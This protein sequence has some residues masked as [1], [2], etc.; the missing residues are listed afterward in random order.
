[1]RKSKSMFDNSFKES[2]PKIAEFF[3]REKT[4]LTSNPA[5][6]R[7]NLIELMERLRTLLLIPGTSGKVKTMEHLRVIYRILAEEVSKALLLHNYREFSKSKIHE[8]KGQAQKIATR[9][10]DKFPKVYEMLRKDVE[11]VFEWDPA[12]KSLE[13]VELAYP[14]IFAILCYR[15]AH[16]LY[17]ENVP[18]IPRFITEYAHSQTGID[19]HP[20]AEI[21]EYFFIDHGTGVVIGET[22]KIGKRVRI[23]HGV[24]LGSKKVPLDESGNP[25]KGVPRHPVIEDDVVIYAHAMVLGRVKVGRGSIIGAGCIITEDVPPFSKITLL[26]NLKGRRD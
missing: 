14:G 8:I 1:M 16:E 12:A 4:L 15:I 20:G 17:V 13:E 3:E 18:L 6:D 25:V 9:V 10:I 5:I 24:T 2:L 11:I 26:E 19:I 7:S 21:D 23:Y 22:C